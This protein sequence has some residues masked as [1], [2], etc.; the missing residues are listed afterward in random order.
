[1]SD[2]S[3]ADGV[4]A[5]TTRIAAPAAA[6]HTAQKCETPRSSGIPGSSTHPRLRWV[7]GELTIEELAR[8]TGMP[9]RNIRS[10]ASRGRLPR[11]GVRARPGYYG[12][13]TVAGLTR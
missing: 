3:R 6:N 12:P 8:E 2:A 10:H 9:V 4:E 7:T 5:T 1:M 11:P 13:G